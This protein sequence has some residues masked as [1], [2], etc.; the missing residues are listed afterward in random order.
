[1]RERHDFDH[2]SLASRLSPLASI[3]LIRRVPSFVCLAL[4][5]G[6]F[7]SGC[8]PKVPAKQ[9]PYTGPT[10]SLKDVVGKINHRN[11][12]LKSL[13]ASGYLEATIVQKNADTGKSDSDFVNADLVLL[14]RPSDEMRLVATKPGTDI[15]DIGT[16]RERFWM[17]V[18]PADKMWWGEYAQMPA[19]GDSRIPVQPNLLLQVLGVST[20]DPDLLAQPAPV[21]RFNPD[22]HAYMITWQVREADRWVA[23]KEIWYDVETFLPKSVFLFD[24]HGRIVLRAH[25]TGHKPLAVE[26]ISEDARPVV[27][28]QYRLYFPDT[29]SRM[30]FRLDEIE[31]TRRG[32]PNDRSFTFPGPEKA[33]VKDVVRVD[34]AQ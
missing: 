18:R 30:S 28:T 17:I 20:I 22:A 9:E 4:L 31:P 11:S 33:G 5:I 26:G 15:F 32:T 34:Q 3:G 8:A 7:L 27:A 21:M 16:N 2:F 13:W 6:P 10:L 14:Y 25:L 23:Q 29:G 24:E 1:M 12:Q 19:G